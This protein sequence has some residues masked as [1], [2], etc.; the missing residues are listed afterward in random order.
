MIP[1]CIIQNSIVHMLVYCEIWNLSRTML[2]EAHM[3]YH[4][5]GRRHN[6]SQSSMTSIS[7]NK[8]AHS[9]LIS[10]FVLEIPYFFV[11]HIIVS[12]I[13]SLPFWC[14]RSRWAKFR[15]FQLSNLTYSK[16]WIRVSLLTRQDVSAERSSSSGPAGGIT[17]QN[18]MQY[19]RNI[20]IDSQECMYTKLR[21]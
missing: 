11:F 5:G 17:Q 15:W 16:L 2:G 18:W 6:A 7:L 9:R 10:C 12:D 8:V 19:H 4:E 1:Q 3:G 20:T 14:P 13:S 21:T